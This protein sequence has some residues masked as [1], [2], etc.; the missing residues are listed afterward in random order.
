MENEIL[1][2]ADL[3][4]LLG[5]RPFKELSSYEDFVKDTGSFEEDTELPE[6]LKDWNKGKREQQEK[7]AAK[8]SK[9]WSL[10]GSEEGT[11]K[12]QF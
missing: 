7:D 4:E 12:S 10:D 5:P 9:L 3:I 1:A 6:G 11:K 2:R 8:E